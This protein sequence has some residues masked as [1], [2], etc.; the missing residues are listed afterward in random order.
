MLYLQLFV[1]GVV[2]GCAIGLVS[3]S[4]SYFYSVTGT[5][6]VAHAGIYTLCGYVAW[7]LV[8][9][10]APFIAALMLAV[11]AGALSGYATQHVLY[12]RLADRQ[13]SPL[14]MMIAS[15]GLLTVLQN[16]VAIVFSP[17]IVQFDMPWRVGHLDIAGV[18]L[19]HPQALIA[20]VSIVIFVGLT[21][22]SAR[23][24]LG[25]RIRAIASNAELAEITRLDPKR[26]FAYVLAISS[27]I[28]AVP[29]VLVGVDQAMQPY[30][31]LIV[32]LTAVV[33]MIAG[34]IGSLPGAFGMSIVLAVIQ[35][36][37]VALIPGRWSIAAVFGI[38]IL[39]ILL[40]PEGLFRRRFS[41]A[42]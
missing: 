34:G 36:L 29:A 17:N 5:F 18:T 28:V 22:F 31:S 20:L 27:A 26:V 10:G 41:R 13:A 1:D 7:A 37:S 39:F 15:I 24:D 23:T 42:L 30:T 25:K 9:A 38:F 2:S 19:S 40:K 6:H 11:L 21:V 35:S 33:A 32:L 16:I 8:A 12:Q 3:I 14:V 4:F